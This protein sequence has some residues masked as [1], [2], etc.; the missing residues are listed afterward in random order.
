MHG[1]RHFARGYGYGGIGIY[2]GDYGY[3][4]GD[5]GYYGDVAAY[6]GSCSYYTY[7]AYGNAY[8]ADAGVTFNAVGW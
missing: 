5:Y 7:D 6:P 2:D 8:C 4:Y 3:D 1:H